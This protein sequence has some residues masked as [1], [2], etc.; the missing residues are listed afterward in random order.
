[1]TDNIQPQGR[2]VVANISLSLDGRIHGLGGEF[3]MGWIVPHAVTDTARDHMVRMTNSATTGLL[4]R[5]N[6]EGFGGYWPTVAKD[7]TADPRDRE[8]AQWLDSVEK[9]VFSSTLT[10]AAWRNSRIARSAPAEEVRRL[11]EQSGGDIVVLSSNSIIRAL[12]EADEV[13]RLRITQCPEIVGGGA[14]LFEDGI[15][16]SSWS[17]T[18]MSTSETGALCLIYDRVRSEA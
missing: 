2:R 12:I 8:F 4:G 15:P 7:D 1:M 16:A 9:V 14:R 10:D 5:K 11:R 3:D 18:D 13:D 17:L 6:Y